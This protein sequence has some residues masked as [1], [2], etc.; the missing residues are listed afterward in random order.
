MQ[1]KHE[2]PSLAASLPR[3]ALFRLVPGIIPSRLAGGESPPPPAPGGWSR[4]PHHPASTLHT[5]GRHLSTGPPIHSS[6][7]GQDRAE[8]RTEQ[9]F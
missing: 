8:H 6:I 5:Q 1:K 3:P 2:A 9:E 4:N 7:L